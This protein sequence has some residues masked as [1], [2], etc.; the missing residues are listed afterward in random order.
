[1]ERMK[2]IHVW[3]YTVLIAG[4]IAALIW[5]FTASKNAKALEITSENQY[6]RA[7]HELVGYVDNIDTLLSKAQLT[8]SPAQL[9]KLS[10]DI[11][12]QSAEAKSCL[13]QLPTSEVQLD[14]TS[15][16]LSQVGDYTYVL[17]QD[18]INGEE[19]SQEQYDNLASMNEYA[20]TLKNT[21][22]DIENRIYSGEVRISTINSKKRGTVADAAGNSILQDL[23]KV[24]KSFDEYPSLIYDGPFSEHIEN[25]ESVMLKN[26]PDISQE[27][28]LVRAEKFLGDRGDGLTFEGLSENTAIQSYTFVKNNNDEQISISVTKKGGYILYYLDS[29]SIDGEK[30]T[31][32]EAIQKASQF[33]QNNGFYS[34]QNSYYEKSGNVATINFAYVQDNVTCYSDLVK[35]R[36]ALDTGDIVGMESKGYLMNH[37]ERELSSPKLTMEEAKSKISTGLEVSGTKLTLV[38][39]DSMRE[40]LCY[41]FKGVFNGKNFLVYVNADNGREE[42]IFLLIESEEG[43]L[44]I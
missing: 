6:N 15:K 11:F 8:K 16:F 35:V 39:K 13:G 23:E 42:E 36:V 27:E 40:V 37:C 12:R 20:A 41:E 30:L 32:D 7:F 44:T 33:L 34:M 29:K 18:M 1:M 19:I 5:G 38:P 22:S 25:R 28:A 17:S 4:I 14:N 9:A 21:L 26:A 3:L 31:I 43:I 24:E 2:S 10:S